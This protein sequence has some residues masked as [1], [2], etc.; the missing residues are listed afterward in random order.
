MK[1][2]KTPALLL[3]LFQTI[4]NAILPGYPVK[5]LDVIVRDNDVRDLCAAPLQALDALLTCSLTLT[6]PFLLLLFL[7][8]HLCQQLYQGRFQNLCRDFSSFDA[9]RNGFLVDFFLHG[10][11]PPIYRH[12]IRGGLLRPQA[13]RYRPAPSGTS[14]CTGAADSRTPIC[15]G[16]TCRDGRCPF[17]DAGASCVQTDYR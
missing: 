3:Y 13:A 16:S 5:G 9:Q 17:P 14:F 1:N 6:F 7:L 15:A 11:S 12:C 4:I 2:L 10:C 8:V